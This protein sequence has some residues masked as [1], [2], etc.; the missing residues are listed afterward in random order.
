MA[1][2]LANPVASLISVPLQN[3]FDWGAGVNGNGFA[4]TLN[5]QPVIPIS[6]SEDWNLISRTILPVAYRDYLPPPDGD[7]F[8]LGD[9]TQ[10][11]FL[12]PKA[13]GPG[14]LIWGIG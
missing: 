3:N 5:I 10:S 7:S 8:G 14:G 6:I 1:K 2:Q 9:T 4:Y 13:P 11:L 12:S